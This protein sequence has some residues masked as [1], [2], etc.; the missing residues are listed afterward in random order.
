MTV[1]QVCVEAAHHA[2]LNDFA[3]YEAAKYGA[4]KF[5]RD[6]VDKVWYAGLNNEDTFYTKVLALDIMAFLNANSR[7]LYAVDILT[8]RT[9]VHGYYAQ[10]DN[11]PQYIIML[12]EAQKKAKWAGMPIANIEL[13][14]MASLAVLSVQHFPSKVDDWEGLPAAGRLWVAWKMAFRLTHLKRQCQILASG[15]GGAT[16]G[17]SWC[18]SRGSTGNA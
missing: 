12:E 11:I 18:A 6:T 15:G 2:H 8:L 1:V 14:M 5:L 3:S 10:A 7:G 9:I 16:R 17:S 4:S 13:M